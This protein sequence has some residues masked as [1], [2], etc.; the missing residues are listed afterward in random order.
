[1]ARLN[2]DLPQ[3]FL[4]DAFRCLTRPEGAT[5]EARN[6]AFHRM[7]VDG[8]TVEYVVP[9]PSPQPSPGRRGSSRPGRERNLNYRG[10][11]RFAGLL[12]RTRE[13]CRKQTPAEELLW[14][15]LRNRQLAGAKFHR[16]Q[17]GDYIC[18]FYCHEAR[19][20]VECDGGPHDMQPRAEKDQTRDAYLR[21]LGLTLLRFKN[22]VVEQEPERFLSEIAS[23]LLSP[24]SQGER[25]RG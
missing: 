3:E 10:G 8:V 9:T 19:L 18:D 17:I 21:S 23:H 25:G 15:L 1:L 7:L 22:Q 11:Y 20:V 13:L 24:L 14:E 16:H 12:E 4:E 2:P 6:H 5:L